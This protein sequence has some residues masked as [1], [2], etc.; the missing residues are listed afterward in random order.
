MTANKVISMLDKCEAYIDMSCL[1]T[2]GQA[3]IIAD[4]LDENGFSPWDGS[5][6]FRYIETRFLTIRDY[7]C[8][9]CKD[10]QKQLLTA[11]Q[12]GFSYATR[13]TA[14]SFLQMIQNEARKRISAEDFDSILI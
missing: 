10:K 1:C 7:S 13:I 5:S 14:L 4:Y 6:M 2:A 3:R 12:C 8:L 11:N 9:V